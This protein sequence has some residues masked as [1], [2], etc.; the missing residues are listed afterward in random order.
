MR[1]QDWYDNY[2]ASIK[3]FSLNE[4]QELHKSMVE[5]ISKMVFFD[6]ELMDKIV[7]IDEVIKEK[8]GVNE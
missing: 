1:K 3:D 2:K 6:K 5:K 8:E 4:L 7:L